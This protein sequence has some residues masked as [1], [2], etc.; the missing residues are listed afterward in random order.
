MT[1]RL[2]RAVA[3]IAAVLTVVAISVPV[4]GAQSNNNGK[5]ANGFR[6]SPV[7]SELTIEKGKSQ[8]LTVTV[9][10]P[11]DI[12]TTA[13]P[14][15]NDFVSSEDES[16]A[17]RLILDNTVAAPKNSFKSLVGA[18]SDMQLNAHQKKDITVKITIPQSASAGG[19]Y[20]AIRFIPLNNQ[21]QQSNVGLT[22]SVGTIV[23]VTVPGNLT[24]KAELVQLAAE[25]NGKPKSFITNG[26]V[27]VLARLKNTGDI[28]I[29]PFGKVQVKN[30]FGKVVTT[31]E[32][33]NTEP[34][35]NI[36]PG[37]TRKFENSLPKAKWFGRYAIEANLGYSQGSGNLITAKAVFWYIPT[38]ALYALVVLVFVIVA[39]GYLAYRKLS[40]KNRRKA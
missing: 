20:G 21:G 35:S 1:T 25:Q 6:I 11:T 23:L 13:K 38:W 3:S 18:L 14:V 9:E 17:P 33:N 27:S 16:G 19:Y 40:A 12:P 31:Y 5:A 29:K 24:E 15:V 10:N 28:H 2:G 36:L 4:A 30:A 39:G 22:A 8:T 37:S 26:D 7:R 32:L 34:R